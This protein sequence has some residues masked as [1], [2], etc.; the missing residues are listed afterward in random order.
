MR[1][2]DVVQKPSWPMTKA[3]IIS[4]CINIST[5]IDFPALSCRWAQELLVSTVASRCC[6]D[7]TVVQGWLALGEESDGINSN[8]NLRW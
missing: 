5:A 4:Y 3:P 8:T 6:S 2:G 7:R 1:S